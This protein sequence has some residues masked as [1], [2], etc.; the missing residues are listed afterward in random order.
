[1]THWKVNVF[2]L[3]KRHT[4]RPRPTFTAGMALIS[5]GS[6]GLGLMKLVNRFD[7]RAKR[8]QTRKALNRRAPPRPLFPWAHRKT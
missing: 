2:C 8:Y 3:A 4:W 6:G 5:A 7:Q 1:M